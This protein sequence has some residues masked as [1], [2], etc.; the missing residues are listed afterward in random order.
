MMKDARVRIFSFKRLTLS[1]V[2]G[3]LVLTGYVSGLFLI[4]RSGHV[5]PAFMA[6]IIRWPR[7]LWIL[8]G[9]R[10]DDRSMVR[11]LLFFAFCNIVLYA[12]IIYFALLALSL[13][14]R[15]PAVLDTPP[16]QPEQFSFDQ[17]TSGTDAA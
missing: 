5:P 11:G 10:F 16:P 3:I 4:D 17:P 9:G 1:V 7:W 2:L 13:V 15:Q 12:T 14:R 8:L 6:T